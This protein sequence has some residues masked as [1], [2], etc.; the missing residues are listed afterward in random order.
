MNIKVEKIDSEEFTFKTGGGCAS[1]DLSVL[2]DKE[3]PPRL[4]QETVIH[5]ILENF[6]MSVCHD[7][8]D[9][10]TNLLVEGL[11]QLNESLPPD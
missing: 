9:E 8:I 2:V 1:C 6:L 10:L 5:E 11:D 4:Q 7:K 3:L